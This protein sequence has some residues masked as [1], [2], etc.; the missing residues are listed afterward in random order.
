MNTRKLLLAAA[1]AALTLLAAACDGEDEPVAP[2]TLK[3]FAVR[4]IDERTSDVAV[5]VEINGLVIDASNEDPAQFDDLLQS[6]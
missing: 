5:P 6:S 2:L 4:D 3:Q 1:T